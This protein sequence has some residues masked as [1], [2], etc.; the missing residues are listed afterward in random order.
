MERLKKHYEKI[1]LGL[2]ALGLIVALAL[3]PFL[4]S[5]ER[6]ALNAE[7]QDIIRRKPKPLDPVP[8]LAAD[9]AALERAQ[10]PLRLDFTQ[11]HNL[12]NP[13]PWLRDSTGRPVRVEAG[14]EPVNS[15]RVTGTT[16]LY[17]KLKFD[18]VSGEN[19]LIGFDNQ[20]ALRPRDRSGETVVSLK[21]PQ[22]PLVT[23]IEVQGPPDKPTGLKLTLNETGETIVLGPDKPYQRVAG[24]SATLRYDPEK[25]VWV[26]QRVGAPLTFAGTQYIVVEITE[27]G[28]VVSNKDN[29]KRTTI[30]FTPQ[31]P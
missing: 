13:V 27:T 4:I 12:F 15:L 24:Y 5:A 29:E 2:V 26:N 14:Q 10:T 28:V 23:L 18:Q 30:P 22:S 6:S 31:S 8:S 1:L 20:V 25:K 3:L 9:N 19:Y 7:S 17:L 21:S 11:N 16:P